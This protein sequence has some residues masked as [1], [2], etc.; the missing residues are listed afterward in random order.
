MKVTRIGE[1]RW[2]DAN[3]AICLILLEDI[4]LESVRAI[5]DTII[6]AGIPSRY[7]HNIYSP[8]EEFGIV[9]IE[10]NDKLEM[11]SYEREDALELEEAI[12]NIMVDYHG[13][14]PS[15]MVL[16]NIKWFTEEENP[17]HQFLRNHFVDIRKDKLVVCTRRGPEYDW[18]VLIDFKNPK[19]GS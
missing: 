6:K 1:N 16:Y 8:D 4:S 7:V 12:L 15:E 5:C 3:S 2:T 11:G 9:K 17:N 10:P 19:L 14:K 18:E 13:L